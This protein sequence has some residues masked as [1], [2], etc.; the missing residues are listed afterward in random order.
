[1]DHKE[2]DEC[3]RI[4]C[5]YIIVFAPNRVSLVIFCQCQ[6]ARDNGRLKPRLIEE[7][8]TCLHFTITMQKLPSHLLRLRSERVDELQERGGEKGESHG[9]GVE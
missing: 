7:A 4:S 2:T 3:R 9:N 5:Y 6:H 1:M 8:P